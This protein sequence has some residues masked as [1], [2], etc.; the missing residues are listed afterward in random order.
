MDAKFNSVGRE[1]EDFTG[2]ELQSNEEV[3][4]CFSPSLG[5]SNQ[6]ETIA[7]CE[8]LNHCLHLTN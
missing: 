4:G 6:L 1:F 8:I 2:K 3:A 5:K 7:S